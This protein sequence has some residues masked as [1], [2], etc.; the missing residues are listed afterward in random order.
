MVC[1]YSS[2]IFE[3]FKILCLEVYTRSFKD[4]YTLSDLC[5]SFLAI[6]AWH[7]ASAFNVVF[8]F[9]LLDHHLIR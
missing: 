7:N 2:L 4:Y 3:V 5:L 1:T 6:E 8:R 9:L